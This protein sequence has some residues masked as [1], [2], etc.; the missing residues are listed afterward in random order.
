MTDTH[1][2]GGDPGATPPP[3]LQA[4]LSATMGTACHACGDPVCGHDVLLALLLGYRDTPCCHACLARDTGQP[5]AELCERTLSWVMA[6][7]RYLRT[8]LWASRTEHDD[9]LLRPT[10]LWPAVARAPQAAQT[11]AS[12]TTMAA[13]VHWDAGDLGCGELVLELRQRMRAMAPGQVLALRATDPG[14]PLDIP[15]WCD[16]TGHAL[17]RAAHPDYLLRRKSDVPPPP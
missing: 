7:D 16:L 4:A 13:D 2:V 3:D 5:P 10:C 6:D 14:A 1:D 9:D 17:L 15:A 11:P 12:G 8:W